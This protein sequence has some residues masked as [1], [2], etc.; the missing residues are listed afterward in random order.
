MA[1]SVAG[2]VAITGV[3]G[4]AL[5]ALRLRSRSVLAPILAHVAINSSAFVATRILARRAR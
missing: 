4:A 5:A 3:A 2:V 1:A